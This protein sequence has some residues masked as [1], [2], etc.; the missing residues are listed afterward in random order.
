MSRYPILTLFQCLRCY[1]AV[2]DSLNITKHLWLNN[3]C[4]PK[5]TCLVLKL[6]I[7]ST[8]IL[9]PINSESHDFV[10][11]DVLLL[12]KNQLLSDYIHGE[13]KIDFVAK[14]SWYKFASIYV[15]HII[16]LQRELGAQYAVYYSFLP[17]TNYDTI[18]QIF[19]QEA[20]K[21]YVQGL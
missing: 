21:Y 17:H 4:N 2:C 16:A 14:I 18:N 12:T 6:V 3:W 13:L 11:A 9:A 20:Q 15:T 7:S 10:S 19:D 1:W 8:A 5:Y